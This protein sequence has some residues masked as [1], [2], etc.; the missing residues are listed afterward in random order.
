M[1]DQDPAWLICEELVGVDRMDCLECAGLS[2]GNYYIGVEY[3]DKSQTLNTSNYLVTVYFPSGM[4]MINKILTQTPVI[5]QRLV[6][7]QCYYE[8]EYT[9]PPVRMRINSLQLLEDNRESAAE[10]ADNCFLLPA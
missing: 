2:S 1:S 6:L 3:G 8:M 5:V 7:S 4:T 10:C 9:G